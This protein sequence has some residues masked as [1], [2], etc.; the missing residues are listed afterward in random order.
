[1]RVCA[2]QK[3]NVSLGPVISN[4]GVKP[5]K[6][7]RNPSFFAMLATIRKPPSGFSKFRF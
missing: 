6:K 4:F 2:S 1:M 3:E 5:L 7:L